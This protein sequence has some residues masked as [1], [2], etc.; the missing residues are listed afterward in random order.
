MILI[1]CLFTYPDSFSREENSKIFNIK[2]KHFCVIQMFKLLC[3][4]KFLSGITNDKFYL[5]DRQKTYIVVEG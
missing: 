5:L 4:I 2:H 1:Q 3:C